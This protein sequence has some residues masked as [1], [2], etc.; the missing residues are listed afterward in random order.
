MQPTDDYGLEFNS[1][2]STDD[3]DDD[4]VNENNK[5]VSMKYP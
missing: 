1:E 4:D 2:S 5:K 3:D